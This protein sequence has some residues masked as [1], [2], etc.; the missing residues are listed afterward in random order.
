MPG[1]CASDA[2]VANEAGDILLAVPP[3][4]LPN[5]PQETLLALLRAFAALHS[6]LGHAFAVEDAKRLVVVLRSVITY[7]YDD[8]LL[9][10]T[11]NPTPLQTMVVNQILRL[12]PSIALSTPLPFVRGEPTVAPAEPAEGEGDSAATAAAAE[13]AAPAAGLAAPHEIAAR[14]LVLTELADYIVLPFGGGQATA[15]DL[16]AAP[17]PGTATAA[18]LSRTG[19]AGV[20]AVATYIAIALRAMDLALA[21]ATA[22][23]HLPEVFE[24]GALE[25]IFAV[26]NFLDA[27]CSSAFHAQC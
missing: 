4:Q 11:E 27:T 25:R 16:A 13:H 8:V 10:D 1:V 23:L 7:P 14:T 26:R 17:T 2:P 22:S 5:L 21:L 15:S 19:T 20:G 3:L 6:T 24:N 9:R 12:D 18:P